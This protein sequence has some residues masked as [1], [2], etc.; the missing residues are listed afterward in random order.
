[1]ATLTM[2]N[3]FAKW[4]NNKDDTAKFTWW[5]T[6]FNMPVPNLFTGS[7]TKDE[8]FL[9]WLWVDTWFDLTWFRYWREVL[10]AIMTMSIDWPFEEWDVVIKMIWRKPDWSEIFQFQQTVHFPDIDD[11]YRYFYQIWS[12]QWVA[13]WEIDV[14]WKYELEVDISW[15]ISWNS[16]YTFDIHNCPDFPW[17]RTQWHLWVDWDKLWYTWHDWFAHL[18]EWD[19]LTTLE[20]EDTW[21]FIW[22]EDADNENELR[23]MSTDWY[24]YTPKLQFRQFAS[25]WWWASWEE[26]WLTPWYLSADTFWQTSWWWC[27]LAHIAADWYKY[28]IWDWHDPYTNPY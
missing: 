18:A 12:N 4:F 26:S 1:M 6:N 23:Y 14:D 9:D 8:W 2:N 5:K 11:W 7:Y 13:P 17:Y 27:H 15:A 25:T 19:K 28:I 21:W 3:R 22:T 10:A 24:V 16:V 20:E